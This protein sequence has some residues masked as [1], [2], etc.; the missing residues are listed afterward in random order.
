MQCNILNTGNR[1]FDELQIQDQNFAFRR[2]GTPAVQHTVDSEL[3]HLEAVFCRLY[4]GFGQN[5]NKNIS[6]LFT[7]PHIQG[8]LFL[9]AVTRIVDLHDHIFALY[10]YTGFCSCLHDREGVEMPQVFMSFAGFVAVYF[11]VFRRNFLSFK[12]DATS[13]S[14]LIIHVFSSLGLINSWREKGIICGY[15]NLS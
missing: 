6:G 4:D 5:G 13:K 1:N 7:V 8:Q 2:T 3:R 14:F 12:H 9:L 15:K 11:I 10:T